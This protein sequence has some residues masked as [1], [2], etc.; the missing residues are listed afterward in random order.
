MLDRIVKNE[1]IMH[2]A[3]LRASGLAEAIRATK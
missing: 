1:S 2:M 3:R